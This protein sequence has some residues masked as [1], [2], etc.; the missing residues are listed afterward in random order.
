MGMHLAMSPRDPRSA[1]LADAA[2]LGSLRQAIASRVP[3]QE[4]DDLAQA[5]LLEA[6]NAV[7]YPT[8]RE[9]FRRW[10]SLKGRSNAI[11]FLRKKARRGRWVGKDD[12]ELDELPGGRPEPAND[13]RDALRFV[14][15][16]L[17]DRAERAGTQTSARWLLLRL[18]GESYA[19]IAQA[20]GTEEATVAK[21][22]GRLRKHLRTAWV[23]VAAVA[24][25]FIVRMSWGPEPVVSHGNPAPDSFTLRERG[26]GEC[27][28][29]KWKACL[30][31][32]DQARE[33]DPNL[34]D[35]P[36]VQ[37]ATREARS[38]LP[39]SPET[40]PQTP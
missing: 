32:L 15:A 12:G 13:A 28:A 34:A 36:A 31:D 5:T 29:G 39:A 40:A 35:D 16:T 10:L 23:A 7:D 22:V 21:S 30:D 37:R 9:G 3:H 14:Q 24:A 8:E 18:R 4:V 38:H 1:F 27:D 11:D 25:F 6:W 2:I 20:E 33:L 19:S 17:D 26:L